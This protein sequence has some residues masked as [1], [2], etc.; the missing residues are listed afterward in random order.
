M[1]LYTT[2]GQKL[3]I[4]GVQNGPGLKD[5]EESDIAAISP[6]SDRSKMGRSDAPQIPS[7]WPIVV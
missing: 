5:R 7:L 4:C 1:K 6:T 3:G 2:I